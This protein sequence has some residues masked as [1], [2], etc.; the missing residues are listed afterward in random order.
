MVGYYLESPLSLHSSH[1]VFRLNILELRPLQSMLPF[2][3]RKLHRKQNDWN[4]MR[5]GI[6][7]SNLP[8][9]EIP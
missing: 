2:A 8:L 7:N 4:V 1:F 9:L 6:P 5:V 3:M